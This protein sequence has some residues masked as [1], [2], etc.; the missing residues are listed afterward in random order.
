ME[1]ANH[2]ITAQILQII[3]DNSHNINVMLT[4]WNYILKENNVTLFFF[5]SEQVH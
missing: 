3:F 4:I 5:V 2:P 1:T